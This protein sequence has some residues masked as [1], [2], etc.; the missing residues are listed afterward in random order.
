MKFKHR[1]K[2]NTSSTEVNLDKYY[3][4]RRALKPQA[5]FFI[6]ML[7]SLISLGARAEL[8]VEQLQSSPD[9]QGN[10]QYKFPLIT[11]TPPEIANNMNLWLQY[12]RLNSIAGHHKTSPFENLDGM[13]GTT[14]LD[15]KIL[16]ETKSLL[17]IEF[18]G[19]YMGAY[20]VDATSRTIFNLGT[21]QPVQ[22]VDILTADGAKKLNKHLTN[23]L[24]SAIDNFL[25][26]TDQLAPSADRPEDDNLNTQK[27]IYTHCREDLEDGTLKHV[28][29]T[30]INKQITLFKSCDFPHMIQA[31]DDLGEI[32]YSESFAEIKPDLNAYGN[33]VLIEA[34]TNCKPEPGVL[35]DGVYNGKLGNRAITL[36]VSRGEFIPIY[37][38]DD[39]GSPVKLH[40]KQGE[41]NSIR[42]DSYTE[43]EHKKPQESFILK[44]DNTGV[45]V[46]TWQ[47]DGGEILPVELHQ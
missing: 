44:T 42:F 1:A 33:C 36:L 10:T 35:Y 40:F 20:P 46:G 21:G 9:D 3:V 5:S 41:A 32:T 12:S 38:S 8:K 27:D 18:Q 39:E 7:L 28:K 6:F 31:L 17:T 22:L 11:G 43:H 37:F 24:Q 26:H 13:H 29:Y 14:A 34:N 25:S 15:Y 47:Q 16:D 45:L 23:N 30:I 19:E 2:E 4:S